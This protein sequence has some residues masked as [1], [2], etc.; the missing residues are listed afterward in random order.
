LAG[1]KRED[2]TFCD[3]FYTPHLSKGWAEWL[4]GMV[5]EL[6]ALIRHFGTPVISGKDS[7][8]GSV[9]T[10][11][12]VISVPPAVFLSTLAKAPDFDKLLR[13]EWSGP[14][15]FLFR[16]GPSFT[17]AAG[18][19]AA[20][21]LKLDAT[22]IDELDLDKF[23]LYLDTLQNLDRNWLRSGRQIGDGG[24]L[25]LLVRGSIANHL[26]VDLEEGLTLADLCVEHRAGAVVEVSPEYV[27][28][29]PPALDPVL[30]GR[31]VEGG[32]S[33]RLKG[34]EL[35]GEQA[36]NAWVSSFGATFQ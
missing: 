32:P 27:E 33:L 13:N 9:V 31:L 1:A 26:A 20:R 28:R 11:E 3:N 34:V 30:I 12:G 7:S 23:K 29:I 17:S 4:T 25:A 15:S 18:T 2:V 35:F 8:A 24:L 14:G 5:T 19:A 36:R 21:A 10:P 22:D 16:I 6:A